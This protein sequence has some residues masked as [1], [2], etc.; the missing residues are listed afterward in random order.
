MGSSESVYNDTNQAVEVWFQLHGGGPPAGGYKTLV[1]EPGADT[2]NKQF[3]LSLGNEVCVK[4]RQPFDE[5][6]ENTIC[7]DEHS[8]P[9][10]GQHHTFTVRDIIGKGTLPPYENQELTPELS[11]LEAQDNHAEYLIPG[12]FALG[13]VA[14]AVVGVKKLRNLGKPVAGVRF[15]GYESKRSDVQQAQQPLMHA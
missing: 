9:G 15:S 7:T 13:S 14:L 6:E 5:N 10:A 3:S 12:L 11:A 1:L 8:P 4:Y 2:G